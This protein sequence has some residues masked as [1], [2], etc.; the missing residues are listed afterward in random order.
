MI[1]CQDCGKFSELNE[2]LRGESIAAELLEFKDNTGVNSLWNICKK[3]ERYLV[4]GLG[5]ILN[6]FITMPKR[7]LYLKCENERKISCMVHAGRLFQKLQNSRTST[8]TK[9][10]RSSCTSYFTNSCTVINRDH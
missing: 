6:V 3:L 4:K 10:K 2:P 5:I 7:I 1:L 9:S 8:N